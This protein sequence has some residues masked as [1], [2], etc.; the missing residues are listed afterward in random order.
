MSSEIKYTL[1]INIGT[2]LES[3]VFSLLNSTTAAKTPN[4]QNVL[5]E[6][7]AMKK[8]QH[9]QNT[10]TSITQEFKSSA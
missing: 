8:A 3:I 5:A 10:E 4:E 1:N 7:S 9:F 2:I 6:K